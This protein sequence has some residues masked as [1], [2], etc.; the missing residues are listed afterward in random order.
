MIE[1]SPLP[2]P[3]TVPFARSISSSFTSPPLDGRIDVTNWEAFA[4]TQANTVMVGEPPAVMRALTIGWLTLRRPVAWCETTQLRLPTG[5]VGTFIVWRANELT[6]DDQRHLLHWME[7]FPSTRVIAR[8]SRALFPSVEQG[9]FSADLYLRL[10]G[11]L[12]LA[13]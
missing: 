12:L 10:N 13:P 3:E 8:S 4:A 7:S 5:P 1:A 9:M 6:P 11:V 2:E